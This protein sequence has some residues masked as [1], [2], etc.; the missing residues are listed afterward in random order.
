MHGYHAYGLTIQSEFPLPELVPCEHARADVLVRYGSTGRARPQGNHENGYYDLTSEEAYFFWS[1]VGAFVVR[2]GNEIIVAPNPDVDAQLLRQPL[3][4]IVL[5]AIIQQR[6]WLALHASAVVVDGAAVAFM[7]HSGWGKSTLAAA[8][9]GRGYQFIADD[10]IVLQVDDQGR[11]FVQPGFPQMKL[12]PESAAT[13]L[14]D[15][16]DQLPRLIDGYPKRARR[17]DDGFVHQPMP[18]KHVYVLGAGPMLEIEVLDPQQALVHLITH[19][20]AV[21]LFQQLLTGSAASTHFLHC[22]HLASRVPVYHLRR[23]QA[24]VRLPELV[25]CVEDHCAQEYVLSHT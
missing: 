22:T 4:G 15:D 8:L 25:K 11:P 13:A 20:Y 9:Y 7:G 5:S 23:P 3:L 17:T 18:L 12:H 6:G 10:L 16:G 24:L 1:Q 14:G 19:S 21:I 2:D